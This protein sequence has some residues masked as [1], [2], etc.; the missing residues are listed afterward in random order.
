MI[1][2]LRILERSVIFVANCS[3]E[4]ALCDA[5]SRPCPAC[6]P[7]ECMQCGKSGC[8]VGTDRGIRELRH[9]RPIAQ[10]A[11]WPSVSLT[12]LKRSR[13]IISTAQDYF[14]FRNTRKLWERER[15]IWV[16]FARPVNVSTCV[17]RSFAAASVRLCL[18]SLAL[19]R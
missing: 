7:A 12:C 17:R 9:A 3:R 18:I 19:P 4:I 16:L 11:A 14:V 13:L 15:L 8:F 2:K 10:S 1:E 5:F 6:Q